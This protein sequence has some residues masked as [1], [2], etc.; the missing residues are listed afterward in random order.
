MMAFPF[1]I[2]YEQHVYGHVLQ[3]LVGVACSVWSWLESI[4]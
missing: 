4:L 2:R 1:S 3:D